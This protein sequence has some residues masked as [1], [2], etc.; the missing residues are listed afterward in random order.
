MKTTHVLLPLLTLSLA[1]ALGQGALTQLGEPLGPNRLEIRWQATNKPPERIWSYRVLPAQWPAAVVSNLMALGPF[2]EKDATNRF[3]HRSDDPKRIR[4]AAGNKSLEIFP[5]IG[6]AEYQDSDAEVMEITDGVPPEDTLLALTRAILPKLGIAESELAKKPGTTNLLVYFQYR[7]AVLYD[8]NNQP[9]TTNIYS[10]GVSF[11]RCLDGIDFLGIGTRGGCRI[12]I[13]NHGK[14]ARISVLW[15]RLERDKAYEIAGR[16]ALI[17][18]LHDGKGVIAPLPEDIEPIDWKAVRSFVVTNAT[19]YYFGERGQVIE[20]TMY[21]FITLAGF[22]E[23][24]RG[25]TDV[26]IDCPVMGKRKP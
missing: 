17:K 9:Y 23:S 19:P 11:I 3:I 4:F 18:M 16:E 7:R 13:G 1:R 10:R 22:V 5:T 24:P 8:T 21:G 15:R 6:G 12:D 14:I 20:H 26:Q 2:S 25:K